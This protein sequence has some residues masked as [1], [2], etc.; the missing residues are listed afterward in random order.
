MATEKKKPVY[1]HILMSHDQDNGNRIEGVFSTRKKGMAEWRKKPSFK[2][3]I[4]FKCGHTLKRH[5]VQ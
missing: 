2:T 3:D 4:M 5:R 1:V